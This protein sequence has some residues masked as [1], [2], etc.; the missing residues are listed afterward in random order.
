LTEGFY[1]VDE[2]S[3]G[4]L[5]N[6]A[7]GLTKSAFDAAVIKLFTKDIKVCFV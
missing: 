4:S 3:N 1:I 5:A 2:D 6:N 7:Q